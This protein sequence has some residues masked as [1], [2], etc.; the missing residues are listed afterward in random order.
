MAPHGCWGQSP[1]TGF[2]AEAPGAA[3]PSLTGQAVGR[4]LTT[5]ITRV[6]FRWYA[7]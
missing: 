2:A 3:P 6:A 4:S 7:S 1:E 5:G